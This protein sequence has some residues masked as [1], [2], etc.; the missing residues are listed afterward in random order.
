MKTQKFL[1]LNWVGL[2][3]TSDM[4]FQ[5]SP[6]VLPRGGD[7]GLQLQN[8]SWDRL[9]AV[10]LLLGGTGEV[11]NGSRHLSPFLVCGTFR[12]LTFLQ[13]KNQN[14]NNKAA[15]YLFAGATLCA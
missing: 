7:Q 10:K 3:Q 9:K 15:R 1:T 12:Y 8:A 6:K 11:G 13:E 4:A 5:G 14:Q 2:G